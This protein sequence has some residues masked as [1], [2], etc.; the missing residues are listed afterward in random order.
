MRLTLKTDYALRVLMY[1]ALHDA[2]RASISEV[3][4]AYEIS[5]N[6]LIKVVHELGRQGFIETSRGKG[7]GIRLA[8][9]ADQIGIG[10]V[11]RAIEDDMALASCFPSSEPA[12]TCRLTNAC[13][14]QG[15][16]HRA[17]AAFMAELDQHTLADM[18]ARPTDP[19][20]ILQFVPRDRIGA[21]DEKA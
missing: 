3:A 14:L 8:R 21:A 18:I 1:L 16:L 15:A 7:G 6:H 12:R 13:A 11:V 9:P 2:R 4:H 20:R 5:E 17:L 10:E 19:A